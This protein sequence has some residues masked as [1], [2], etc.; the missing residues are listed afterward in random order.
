MRRHNTVGIHSHERR[1][2]A[3]VGTV[4]DHVDYDI[5]IIRPRRRCCSTHIDVRQPGPGWPLVCRFG[6]RHQHGACTGDDVGD[7]GQIGISQRIGDGENLVGGT[8]FDQQRP[9]A[10]IANRLRAHHTSAV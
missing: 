2:G 5:G 3:E 1:D 9:I 7:P 6:Q 4:V 8:A 10:V